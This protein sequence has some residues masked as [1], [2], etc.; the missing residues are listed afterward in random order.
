VHEYIILIVFFRA[1]ILYENGSTAQ[2]TNA[3]IYI[4]FFVATF[5]K[6]VTIHIYVGYRATS[7]FG[8]EIRLQK[9]MALVMSLNP[10]DSRRP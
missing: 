7:G 3:I 1:A 9:G 8:T 10:G 2:N 5:I 4:V 6:R